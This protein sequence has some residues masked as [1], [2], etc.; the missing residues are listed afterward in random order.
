MRER[1][2]HRQ[3]EKQAP[4]GEPGLGVNPRT[5]GSCPELKTD[6]QQLSHPAIPPGYTF[7]K[8]DFRVVV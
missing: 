6:A 8:V 2:R 4:Y 3:R 7:L 5:L 1:Q